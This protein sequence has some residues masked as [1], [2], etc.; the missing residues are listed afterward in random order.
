VARLSLRELL[1]L[2]NPHSMWLIPGADSSTADTLCRPG[3]HFRDTFDTPEGHPSPPLWP[4]RSPEDESVLRTCET[5][6]SVE[7]TTIVLFRCVIEYA[8]NEM[9][10]RKNL[11]PSSV[12]ESAAREGQ[13]L[14]RRRLRIEDIPAL[15]S[16][17]DTPILIGSTSAHTFHSVVEAYEEYKSSG[18]IPWYIS[19]RDC[20]IL[21]P[22]T[23]NYNFYYRVPYDPISPEWDFGNL[24]DPSPKYVYIPR[25]PGQ[26]RTIG[27]VFQALD[28]LFGSA[29]P[30]GQLVAYCDCS[31]YDSQQYQQTVYYSPGN[32][33]VGLWPYA[34]EGDPSALLPDSG[35]SIG[36]AL[37][38]IDINPDIPVVGSANGASLVWLSSYADLQ[39]TTGQLPYVPGACV[40]GHNTAELF[41]LYNGSPVL[42]QIIEMIVTPVFQKLLPEPMTV[43]TY[44]RNSPPADMTPGHSY[45]YVFSVSGPTDYVSYWDY[46]GDGFVKVAQWPV[47]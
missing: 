6:L 30:W 5:P 20:S 46:W 39:Y 37:R 7:Y 4:I 32:S 40:W 42:E 29:L 9:S 19:A 11:F 8:L 41:S 1:S 15:H 22:P 21:Q 34:D 31:W 27:E 23:A 3:S 13:K 28:S 10:G 45:Q 25:Y 2:L 44:D 16:F 12:V 35:E 17:F 24:E 26:Y 38:G 18:S 14:L 47:K 43:N 33:G 36:V